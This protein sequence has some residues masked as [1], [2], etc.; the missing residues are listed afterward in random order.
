MTKL[1][2]FGVLIT[3]S[4]KRN[5]LI[6]IVVKITNHPEDSG[7]PSGGGLMHG[8]HGPASVQSGSQPS[9]E[10]QCCFILMSMSEVIFLH[11]HSIEWFDPYAPEHRRSVWKHKPFW[12]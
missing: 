7:L 12:W 11:Q 10:P 8:H 4:Q 6:F 1:V 9:G 3:S 2:L 5:P